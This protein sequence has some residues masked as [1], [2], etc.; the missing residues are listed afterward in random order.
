VVSG[1]AFLPT[2]AMVVLLGPLLAAGLGIGFTI[3]P[4]MNTGTFGVA[5]R[6]A[7]VASATLNTGQ[8]VGG[9]IGTSL[10][11]TVFASSVA[12]YLATHRPHDAFLAGLATAIGAGVS[13]AFSEGLSDTGD[14]TG[15]G[16]PFL[17]GAITG[18]G[19]FLGG[20]LHTLPFLIPQYRAAVLLALAAMTVELLALAYIRRRFFG[21]G[22]LSSFLSITLGG[23]VIAAVGIAVGAVG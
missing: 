21:A 19:T 2:I 9:S 7:G 3:A 1:L 15:R 13:M 14:L 6:D 17:R 22:F 12:H 10:L 8:Q 4:S 5:A 20:V 16:R 23:A 11:H 18:F